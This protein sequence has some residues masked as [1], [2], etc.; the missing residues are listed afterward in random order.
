[1][2]VIFSLIYLNNLYLQDSDNLYKKGNLRLIDKD[3]RVLSETNTPNRGA[4]Y[5]DNN[6][7]TSSGINEYNAQEPQ[8]PQAYFIEGTPIS[9]CQVLSQA[10]TAYYLTQDIYVNASTLNEATCFKITANNITLVGNNYKIENTGDNAIAIAVAGYNIN[11]PKIQNLNAEKFGTGIRFWNV[12][13]V[14][15]ADN[16]INHY[17]TN[18]IDL[19]NSQNSVI[20]RNEITN[21][22]VLS[23]WTIGIWIRKSNA[24]TVSSN[25]ITNMSRNAGE[26]RQGI[27][28]GEGTVSTNGVT[29]SYI[30]N[31]YID[32]GEQANQG[33][34]VVDSSYITI[35]ENKVTRNYD[36]IALTRSNNN[37]ILNN[38]VYNQWHHNVFIAD[39]SSYNLIEGNL[40][41]RAGNTGIAIGFYYT[42]KEIVNTK[43]IH[44]TILNAYLSGILAGNERINNLTIEKNII[45][46]NAFD[47][48]LRTDNI[49]FET[50]IIIQ[51]NIGSGDRPIIFINTP[52]SIYEN[53]IASQIIIYNADNSTFKNI[54]INGSYIKKNNGLWI[55]NTDNAQFD[56]IKSDGNYYGINLIQS[57]KNNFNNITLENNGQ[58]M[59]IQKSSH[60]NRINKSSLTGNNI[61]LYLW[62]SFRNKITNTKVNENI[63]TGVMLT[64]S[65]ENTFENNEFI[66]NEKGISFEAGENKDDR[67]YNN[68]FKNSK[69]NI[70]I[71]TLTS[72]SFSTSLT[73]GT[74]IVGGPYIGGNYW[75]TPNGDGFSETCADEDENGICD[76]EYVLANGNIDYYPLTNYIQNT[77]PTQITKLSLYDED[78]REY[79]DKNNLQNLG[80]YYI[81]L[82]AFD[83]DKISLWKMIINVNDRSGLVYTQLCNNNVIPIKESIDTFIPNTYILATCSFDLGGLEPD[84]QVTVN[85]EITDS[86]GNIKTYNKV[87]YAM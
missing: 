64:D 53:I 32:L 78:G 51:N 69:A 65:K 21:S 26:G 8:H 52:N 76:E 48:T 86:L 49:N 5:Q 42:Q 74:N 34:Q 44:N 1:M 62:D 10:N 59:I 24:V 37:K 40:L 29:N 67:F 11:K 80:G 20:L 72:N 84:I 38:H 28:F 75:A 13:E 47:L 12:N 16:K 68:F 41:E 61:G 56:D 60:E 19:F 6:Q 58:G 87:F 36:G 15:I 35:Q 83:L 4:F 30:L 3:S 14:F 22:V 50:A 70:Y 46:E 79:S 2:I 23:T 85:S 33:I 73:P 63:L 71:Y 66:S 39:G 57:T 17:N 81:D 25:T 43:I 55:I 31:N 54:I 18:A 82:E 7:E 77:N 45:K 27:T 9:S